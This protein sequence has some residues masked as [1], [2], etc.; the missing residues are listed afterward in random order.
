MKKERDRVQLY[1]EQLQTNFKKRIIIKN[2]NKKMIEEH[3][4]NSTP[5]LAEYSL[6]PLIESQPPLLFAL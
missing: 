1:L 2:N 6:G 5:Y 3:V 4:D